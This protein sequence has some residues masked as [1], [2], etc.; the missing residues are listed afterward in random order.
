MK[1][2]HPVEVEAEKLPSFSLEDSAIMH[3]LSEYGKYLL[4]ATLGFVALLLLFYRFSSSDNTKTAA[5]YVIAERNFA[6]IARDTDP[7]DSLAEL[8]AILQNHPE[9]QPKYDGLLAQ[10]LISRGDLNSATPFAIRALKRTQKENSPFYTSYAETTL[11]IAEKKFEE[12]LGQAKE[13]QQL[14]HT[15][16]L[17]TTLS[18]FNLLRI[19]SLQRQLGLTDQEQQTWKEWQ[20]LAQNNPTIATRVLN[21]FTEGKMTLMDYIQTRIQ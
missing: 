17:T 7:Q 11:L 2:N 15:E 18:A 4:W 6:K 1:K 21:H 8:K 16:Q 13:L 20:A 10:I 9:L 3:W 19:A 12:A 5:D 14:M